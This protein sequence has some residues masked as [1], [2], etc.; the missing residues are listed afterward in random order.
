MLEEIKKS[1]HF[2]KENLH[3]FLIDN[4]TDDMKKMGVQNYQVIAD[5]IAS[6]LVERLPIPDPIKII[7]DFNLKVIFSDLTHEDLS[8]KELIKELKDKKIFEE[9][10]L[11]P[12]ADFG[13]GIIIN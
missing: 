3:D 13:K 12:L 6:R 5:N 8:D 4:P 1:K 9:D 7:N 2:L 10:E 11:S